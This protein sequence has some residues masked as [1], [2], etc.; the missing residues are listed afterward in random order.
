MQQERRRFI[1]NSPCCL[2]IPR[3]VRFA[4]CL[5]VECRERPL[6]SNRRVSSAPQRKEL[7]RRQSIPVV[8]PAGSLCHEKR[9]GKAAGRERTQIRRQEKDQCGSW[10]ISDSTAPGKKSRE[11]EPAGRA[12]SGRTSNGCSRKFFCDSMNHNLKG[13]KSSRSKAVGI[14]LHEISRP[15]ISLLKY[16]NPNVADFF[17]GQK[18]GRDASMR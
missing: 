13:G 7:D 12:S 2:S 4:E 5:G 6:D 1:L 9:T 14:C 18:A 15:R 16:V 17:R 11:S 8:L 3:G 10:L